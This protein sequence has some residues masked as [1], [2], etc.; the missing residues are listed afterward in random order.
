MS[1]EQSQPRAPKLRH[2]KKNCT[3]QYNTIVRYLTLSKILSTVLIVALMLETH[4]T[5]EILYFLVAVKKLVINFSVAIFNEI[6]M[7]FVIMRK[8]R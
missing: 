5:L 3:L 2:T 7:V 1:L 6:I 8:H 4:L